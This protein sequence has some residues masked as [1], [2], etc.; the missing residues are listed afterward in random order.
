MP[1]NVTRQIPSYDKEILK[2]PLPIGTP[3]HSVVI[4]ATKISLN[5]NPDQRT[6]VP[7]GTVLTTS[8]SSALNS[9][10]NPNAVMPYAGSGTIIGILARPVDI[11][12]SATT[13]V[14]A[15]PAYYHLAVFA[16]T[17]VVN[18]TTYAAALV[19]ALPTCKFE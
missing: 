5:P 7:A 17:Q 11:L 9:G 19:T 4:D 14:E 10:A 16:T 3:V 6:V 13:G 12:A 18:F 2:Y 15:A 8:Q 1:W